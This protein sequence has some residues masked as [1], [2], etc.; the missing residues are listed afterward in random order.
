MKI[1]LKKEHEILGD[2]GQILNVKNGYARN[3]LIPKG[4]ATIANESNLKSF[5]E[6]KKQRAKKV[7]K[8]VDEAQKISSALSSNVITFEMK[9]GEEDKI[10][11]SVTSQMIFD[12][13][14]EK[15][16]ENLDR[17][18]IILKEAIKSLGE[19]EVEVKL[20][21]S[22]VAL[23]KVNVVK[24]NSASEETA[25]VK[26]DELKSEA[27]AESNDENIS[28]TKEEAEAVENKDESEVVTPDENKVT[29]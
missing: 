1:I 2:E 24:E 15:G 22:V 29:E 7:Q 4:Y 25:E 13:L 14:V 17:K 27:V 12:R 10:F 28:E 23:I 20:Q 18:K 21:H 26:S 5:E 11:G 9:T 16:F 8:L 3:Y 6:I 19:H